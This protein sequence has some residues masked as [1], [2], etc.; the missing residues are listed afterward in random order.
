[1]PQ[2]LD[3]IA[4]PELN[5]CPEAGRTQPR[6]WVRRLVIWSEPGVA[7]REVRLRPGL[8]IVWSPDPADQESADASGA[9]GHG[10]GKT[11][12]CRLLR[13]CL[14]EDHF[15]PKAQEDSIA[16]AFKNGMVGA[17]VGGEVEALV[18]AGGELAGVL[19]GTV[20]G[21]A[22]AGLE[23]RLGDADLGENGANLGD[24]RGSAEV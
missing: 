21:Y 8:N 22:G 17:E 9:L 18:F 24:L 3:L 11:L 6:L 4:R 15:A 14:G 10:S 7:L 13:Y 20:V 2:Q 1:M 16:L 23:G 5:L 19:S 12:F